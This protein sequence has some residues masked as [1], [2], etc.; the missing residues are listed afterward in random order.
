MI[1]LNRYLAMC[2]AA[3]RRKAEEILL[4]GRVRVNGKIVLLPSMQIEPDTAEVTL[5][6]KLL[7]PTSHIYIVMN[8]P[9]GYVCAVSDKFDPV[10]LELLPKKYRDGRVFPVG[11][12]DRETEGLL[13][14]TNDG[15][16]AHEITHPSFK[17]TKE[18]EVQ[19]DRPMTEKALARWKQGYEIEGH[20]VKPLEVE[21]IEGGEVV[22]VVIG[23]GLKREVREMV[24]LAG[25]R[26]E[27]LIR[28]RI[29]KMKLESLKVG[30]FCELTLSDL[31]QK[32]YKGGIV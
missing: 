6:G 21:M 31:E 17:I 11:R 2:G 27:A 5:D 25:F 29:G 19:L 4:Q 23:E 24:R 8:K 16:F 10:I 12:L 26:T 3:S 15:D 32:I 13:I 18:Y 20:F 14:L 28:R 30:E 1:R 9:A 22:R 7:V